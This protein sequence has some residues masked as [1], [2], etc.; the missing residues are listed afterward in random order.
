MLAARIVHAAREGGAAHARHPRV[1]AAALTYAGLVA[2]AAGG[3]AAAGV[4]PDEPMGGAFLWALALVFLG[5]PHGAC[6]L[7]AM[8][9]RA[10]GWQGT[11][12]AMARY[13][14]VLLA[15]AL[16]FW[17]APTPTLLAFLVLTMVHFGR[18]DAP[19]LLGLDSRAAACAWGAV[20]IAGPLA[21]WPAVA[22]APFGVIA[23]LA[24]GRADLDAQAAGVLSALAASLL[25][26]SLC[27]LGVSVA[28]AW[29]AG[30]ASAAASSLAAASTAVAAAALLP[31]LMAVGLY[32]LG[33]HALLH[34]L[35]VGR[36]GKPALGPLAALACAH[37][38]SLPLL[39][40]SLAIASL[41]ALPFE[42]HGWIVAAALG[43]L[44]FCV[45]A[46]LPHHLLWFE[47]LAP[48]GC[49]NG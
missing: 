10:A 30:R 41:L 9:D 22:W 18:S 23:Q 8:R 13:T 20:V 31:P 34:C 38:R 19:V 7:A 24:G 1:T 36:E 46:T 16:A 14:L 40:P 25:A 39:V 12:A 28:H 3:V 43:F 17:A 37:A 47:A 4:R 35:R 49:P 32:F 5:M 33:V 48:P 44:L 29:R 42:A 45:A 26:G 11:L 27:V 6:D 21:F 2:A 15:C